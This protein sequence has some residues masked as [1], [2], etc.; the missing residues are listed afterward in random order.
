MGSKNSTVEDNCMEELNNIDI[1]N[2]DLS[3]ID[4]LQ[5]K[6]IKEMSNRMKEIENGK[7]DKIFYKL[8]AINI[9]AP[10]LI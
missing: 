9:R 1:D 3:S 4:R 5:L 7:G 2:L 8:P 10:S 6:A